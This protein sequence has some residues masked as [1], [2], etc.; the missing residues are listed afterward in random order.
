MVPYANIVI[1]L[2]RDA[3][4]RTVEVVHSVAVA[5]KVSFAKRR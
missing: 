2:A 1:T 3:H 5:L 4:G